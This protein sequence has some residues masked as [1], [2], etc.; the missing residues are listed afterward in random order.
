MENLIVQAIFPNIIS[1]IVNGVILAIFVVAVWSGMRLARH[2]K[3]REMRALKRVERKVDERHDQILASSSAQINEGQGTENGSNEPVAVMRTE[4][5]LEFIPADSVIFKRIDA[6]GR[7]R[8]R[9]V[10]INVDVLQQATYASEMSRFGYAFPKLSIS[11]VMI[12]GL[13]GTFLGLS[14]MVNKISM[15]MPS[16]NALNLSFSSLQMSLREMDTVFKG[17]KTAFSTSIV[18]IVATIICLM[19]NYRIRRRQS[20][21][22]HKLEVFTVEKLIPVTVPPVESEHLLEEVSFRLQ[23]SFDTLNHAIAQNNSILNNLSEIE[24]AF[25]IIVGHIKDITNREES[26]HFENVINL[27][28]KNNELVGRYVEHWSGIAKVME[29]QGKSTENRINKIVGA[30]EKGQEVFNGQFDRLVQT[31]NGG[32]IVNFTSKWNLVA[33]MVVVVAFVVFFMFGLR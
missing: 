26:R 33:I 23:D 29:D 25:N 21:F 16:A 7:M 2:Y 13:F 6:I 5:L 20:I 30:F 4:E 3:K 19:V 31:R 8:K 12:L 11:L 28:D 14:L 15:I 18:G 17:I 22:F 1:A 24:S 10:K 9:R 32:V 27:L